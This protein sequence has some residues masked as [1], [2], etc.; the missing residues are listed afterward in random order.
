RSDLP[1]E[2]EETADIETFVFDPGNPDIAAGTEMH[3]QV[4]FHLQAAA[5]QFQADPAGTRVRS[6]A[7]S[8]DGRRFRRTRELADPLAGSEIAAGCD[9]L[10]REPP[11]E[12]EAG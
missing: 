6:P 10:F 8:E 11:V 7:A 1:P 4:V 12:F 3:G 9:E 5:V 2:P